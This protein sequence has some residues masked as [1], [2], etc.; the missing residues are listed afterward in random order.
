MIYYILIPVVLAV[1]LWLL[2]SWAERQVSADFNRS[3]TFPTDANLSP[4]IFM[5]DIRMDS[6]SNSDNPGEQR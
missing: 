4:D 6:E 5:T 3:F 1:G 2:L